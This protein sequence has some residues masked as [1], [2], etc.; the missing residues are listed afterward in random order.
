MKTVNL[1][2]LLFSVYNIKVCIF[3]TYKKL[4]ELQLNDLLNA[5]NN[6]QERLG[7]F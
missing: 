3:V 2:M 4:V 7:L 5:L 6:N 1:D